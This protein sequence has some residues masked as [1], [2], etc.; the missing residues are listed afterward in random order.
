MAFFQLFDLNRVA[1]CDL[2]NSGIDGLFDSLFKL[3]WVC[4]QGCTSRRGLQDLVLGLQLLLDS[5]EALVDLVLELFNR[6][7]G[8]SPKQTSLVFLLGLS[9]QQILVAEGV[10]AH[11]ELEERLLHIVVRGR[12]N[13]L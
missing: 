6:L 2:L 10:L 9:D 11:L 5:K 13:E 1:L 3:S 7:L 8:V 12:F 4:V